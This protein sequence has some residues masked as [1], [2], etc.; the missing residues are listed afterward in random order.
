MRSVGFNTAKND[1]HHSLNMTSF[2][3]FIVS[4]Q[5]ENVSNRNVSVI[6]DI[7]IFWVLYTVIPCATKHLKHQYHRYLKTFGS[8]IGTGFSL[9]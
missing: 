3:T 2:M 5:Q 4:R 9:K 8:Q 1:D 7:A 6:D